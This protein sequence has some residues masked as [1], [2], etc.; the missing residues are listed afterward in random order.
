[1]VTLAYPM[2]LLRRLLTNMSSTAPRSICFSA[3]SVA[4]YCLYSLVAVV[5]WW[6][7]SAIC[8]PVLPA[9]M[10][11]SGPGLAGGMNGIR[12]SVL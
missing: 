12:L 11:G 10:I 5:N 8:G 2:C 6:R 3:L 9:G 7:M 1:M 4:S